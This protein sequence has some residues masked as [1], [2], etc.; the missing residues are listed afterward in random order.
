MGDRGRILGAATTGFSSMQT[1][2]ARSAQRLF[3]DGP[4]TS[5]MWAIYSS[6]KFPTHHIFFPPRL[7]VVAF[8]Q[9]PHVSRP[10]PRDQLTFHRL[11]GQQANRPACPSRRRRTA[12]H[13]DDALSLLPV[14]QQRRPGPGRHIKP[15]P[16][17]LLI[18]LAGQP[19]RFG[20][21]PRLA[22]TLGS[23]ALR[24]SVAAP[25]LATPSVPAATRRSTIA[26]S[27]RSRRES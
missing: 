18:A 12:D 1:T 23:P 16:A 25:K 8:Q 6:S 3:V 13:R 2:G 14:Q 9:D 20:V 24:P 4:N 5:S 11:F 19:H 15:A 17:P 21:N 7:Q 22:A 26:K 10:Y 27:C